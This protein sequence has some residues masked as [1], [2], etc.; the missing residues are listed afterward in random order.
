LLSNVENCANPVQVVY[1][2]PGENL[3]WAASR[4]TPSS[5][6]VEIV[7][8]VLALRHGGADKCS[9]EFPTKVMVFKGT[10]VTPNASPA[11]PREVFVSVTSATSGDASYAF[12]LTSPLMLETG[13]HLFVAMQVHEDADKR[14]CIVSCPSG[15]HAD[16]N[17]WG[18]SQTAPFDWR[19]LASWGINYD[20]GLKAQ[21]KP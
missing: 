15:A 14:T 6:P 16:R 12:D 4:L 11:S 2:A 3:Q 20:F 5:Y 8:I 10:E 9:A 21:A 18:V 13:E 19:E 1:P 7:K 17:Y